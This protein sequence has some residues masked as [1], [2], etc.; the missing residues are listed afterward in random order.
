MTQLAVLYMVR[1]P[2]YARLCRDLER[3]LRQR[4]IGRDRLAVVRSVQTCPKS[5]PGSWGTV[6][7]PDL[8]KAHDMAALIADHFSGPSL[9]Y[10]YEPKNITLPGSY[11]SNQ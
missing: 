10:D 7:Q 5:K 4:K 6:S 2:Y 8:D 1:D 9:R 3:G 11:G